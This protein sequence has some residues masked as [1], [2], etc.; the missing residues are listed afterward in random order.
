MKHISKYREERNFTIAIILHS[1]LECPSS[2]AVF[3]NT[4]A[5]TVAMTTVFGEHCDISAVL[6][7]TEVRVLGLEGEKRTL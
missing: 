7:H 4:I 3:D 5:A 2:P 1:Q 6:T